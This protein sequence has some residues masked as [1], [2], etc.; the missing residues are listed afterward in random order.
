MSDPMSASGSEEEVR[1]AFAV[2]RDR[3]G[4]LVKNL[5]TENTIA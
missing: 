2:G 3:I 4:E 1:Q 5:V